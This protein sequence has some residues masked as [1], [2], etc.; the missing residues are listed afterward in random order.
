MALVF[1]ACSQYEPFDNA[2]FLTKELDQRIDPQLAKELLVPFELDEVIRQDLRERLS[3]VGSERRRTNQILDFVFAGLDLQYARTPTRNAVE[4]YR[5][6]YG[7]CLSFVNL[8][9]G[10]AREQRLNPFYVEV[11]DY[12]RWS[13]QDGV[14]VS[15]GHIVAG[16]YIDGEL[17]TFDFLP[18]Q[19]KSYRNFKPITDIQA[20]AHYYNNLG[21]EALLAGD[22][23]AA[24]RNLRAAAGLA[25]D[26]DKGINN[27]GVVYLRLG[28]TA[29]AIE[30]YRRGLENHVDNVPL[31]TNLTRAYQKEGKLE[32]AAKLLDRLEEVDQ[33][34]P[35]FYVYRGDQALA[36]QDFETALR[37]MRQAFRA[38]PELPEVHVGLVRVYLALGKFKEAR[39]HV[40]RALKLDATHEEARKYAT[41]LNER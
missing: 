2:A 19:P 36:K 33:A 16:M 10:V 41:M 39:H 17:S 32:E 27:L 37:Y 11:Q 31:M 8:F 21:A 24:E 4:T 1:V 23:N 7:N 40:E 25:P 22:L 20:M 29:R 35:F 6:G 38:D 28:D 34:N 9:V 13:Y 12:Q 18:Y 14:V 26:F 30:L 3:P 15:R 5:T